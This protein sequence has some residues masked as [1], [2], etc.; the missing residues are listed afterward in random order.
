MVRWLVRMA[1]SVALVAGILALPTVLSTAAPAFA[2]TVINGCTVVSNPTPSNFTNCPN[3]SIAGLAGLNL[4]YANFS[5]STIVADMTDANL[6]DANLSNIVVF[7]AVAVPNPAFPP[8]PRI[9]IEGAGANF[10]GANLSGANL[11]AQLGGANLTDANLT[12]AN[13]SH[14]STDSSYTTTGVAAVTV[15]VS[16]TLTGANLTG[17]P[18]VP[19][20]QSVTATSQAGAVVTWSTPLSLAGLTPGSCTPASGSTFP[21]FSSTVTCQVLDALGDVATGTLQVNVAPTTQYFTRVLVP[22][23]GTVV[24]GFQVLDAAAGDAPGITSDAFELSGGTLT[25]PVVIAT[26]TPTL[27]GWLAKW[28]TTSVPNGTYSLQ[29]VATDKAANTDTS[30]PIS[31]TVNNQPPSTAVLIPSGGA[32][33]SGAKALLDASASSAAGIASVTFEVSGNGLTNQVV[34]T[35]TPTIYGYLAQWN[36]TAVPN[37]TYS[38]SSVASDTVAESTTSAPVTIAVNNPPPSTTVVLPASGAIETSDQALVMDAV[39]SP[40]VTQV[41]INLTFAGL[42]VVSS[43]TAT[44]TLYGWIGVIPAMLPHGPCDLAFN[45][46]VQSVASYSGGVSGTSAPVSFTY[47]LFGPIADCSP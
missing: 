4:S 12:S 22:S 32:T 39:A 46:S 2:D 11:S 33:V 24:Q 17:T 40:G 26:A 23:D 34:A 25:N 47:H 41:V 30:E 16:A 29:S 10:T 21:L 38:L 31:I 44:P 45:A 14:A 28:N 7:A 43:V 8:G 6:T 15:D 37:G 3:M 9:L 35:G 18:L 1:G 19:S 36:T 20:N 5:G 27:F 13:L 42:G